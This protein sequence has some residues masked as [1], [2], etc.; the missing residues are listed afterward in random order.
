MARSVQND[1]FNFGY[2]PSTSE[3][4]M[5]DMDRLK[6]ESLFCLTICLT[7]FCCSQTRLN[8]DTSFTML[9]PFMDD[10]NYFFGPQVAIEQYED[11]GRHEIVPVGNAVCARAGRWGRSPPWTRTVVYNIDSIV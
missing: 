7:E 1:A 3:D 10:V 8:V 2:D 9:K 4:D 11:Y 6:F 5:F